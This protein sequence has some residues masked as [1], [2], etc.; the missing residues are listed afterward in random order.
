MFLFQFFDMTLRIGLNETALH[1]SKVTCISSG[2]MVM[3]VKDIGLI[4][5][6]EYQSAR[7]LLNNQN[8]C[9]EMDITLA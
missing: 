3:C 5:V 8:S 6:W 1:L 7:Q 9:L 2:N 4:H